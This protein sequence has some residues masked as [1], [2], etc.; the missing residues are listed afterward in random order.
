[1]CLLMARDEEAPGEGAFR[2][3]MA[4]FVSAM[5]KSWSSLPFRS[6]SLGAHSRAGPMQIF[7]PDLGNEPL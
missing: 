7:T 1:M 4:P 2:T 6:D 3:C 5:L